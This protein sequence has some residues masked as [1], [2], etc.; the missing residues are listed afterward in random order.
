MKRSA[1]IVFL[2]VV[3]SS[4]AQLFSD[5]FG[6]AFASISTVNWPT[7]CRGGS[8][9]SFNTSVGSC[10]AAGDYSYGMSGFGAYITTSAIAI[11]AT[12]YEV[13]FD[14]SFN[15]AFSFP[16]VEIRSGATCGTTLL[17]T[18]TLT[19]TS[20]T[21]TS[22]TID[23]SA[24]SGQTIY[25][26]FKSNT[27]SASVYWDNILVDLSSGG[28]GGGCL[29]TDDFGT[30]FTSIS[31]T[32]WPTA[33]RGGSPSSFNTSVGSCGGGADYSYSMSGFGQYITSMALTIPSTGYSLDFEYSFNYTFSFPSVEIRT[34]GTCGTTLQA[35]HTLTNTAGVCTPHSIDLSAYNGQTI[36]IRFRSNTSS[37]TFYLDD[38]AVCGGTGG[39]GID[40]KW[41][42]NFNDNDLILDYTGIDGD[43][44]CPG[45]GNWTLNGGASLALVP[46]A[47]WNGNSNET[48]AFLDNMSNVYYVRLDRNEWIESPTI[49]LSGMSSVKISFYAKSSSAGTGG[50]DSWSSVSDHLRLQI[51]DGSAWITVKDI[52]QG[53]AAAENQISPALPF[54][55]FCFSA[56]KETTSPG[57]Y[58]YNAAPN[59]NSAYFHSNFKFRVVFEGGFT[60][61]PF[62]W[63]DDFTFRTDNDGYSTMIPCGVSFWNQPAATS[64]GQD[65]GTSGNNNAE[66]GVELELDNAIGFP[67]V[68]ASEANDGDAVSQV[69]GVNEAERV[70]F[71][72]LSE[73]KIQFAFPRVHYY[74]P[75]IGNQS[76]VMSLDNSYSG[77]GYRYYAVEYISCD[78]ASGSIAAP[79][80]DF[81]YYYSFEYG[82]EFI[83]VF[84]H[85]N[86]SGIETGGGVTS[87]FERFNAPDVLST[88]NCG[89]VLG[90]EMN[91]FDVFEEHGVAVI[92]WS[93]LSERNAAHFE[94]QRSYDAENYETVD[95]IAAAGNSTHQID[96]QSLDADWNGSKAYYRL[97]QTDFDGVSEVFGPKSLD[98][99]N[100]QLFPN[101]AQ[102]HFE[103]NAKKQISKIQ[104]TDAYG[105]LLKISASIE[106]KTAHI[107]FEK[108]A[109]G[110]YYVTAQMID[111]SQQTI[112]LFIH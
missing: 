63:V 29:L 48:E 52:T 111:G 18:T 44:N 85:L 92:E 23:L 103:V 112:T 74:A 30:A 16:S 56:Y 3:N 57:N 87:T 38:V 68:W 71:A 15:L 99:N 58:Y 2:L 27:S 89:L 19:N 36:F 94:V 20:G 84:Y 13:T 86:T 60:G 97:L 11:P 82:N 61:A 17:A 83:P 46:S 69:F 5:D 43:E 33:C 65:T 39:S 107:D 53:A 72:V 64:Y 50:G 90:V 75:D 70:V 51:W 34:G 6:T 109:S 98:K 4:Y 25:I 22:Q 106:H 14:Y 49:D 26:R 42:D 32:N 66:K 37:A 67:P 78:L 95:K 47:G 21:C 8:P 35:T 88:D 91:S 101:P 10:S 7:A 81:Q 76:T 59:V 105:K 80:D 108:P 41:A 31:T 73:Q 45:C 104:V 62:A 9:S 110:I 55:Y 102:D 79:T 28:G 93:T 96:Y 54:N 100:I 40:Q 1:L 77:P 12:G 24:Y